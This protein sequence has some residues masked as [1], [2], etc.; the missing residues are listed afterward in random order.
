[1]ELQAQEDRRIKK[2]AAEAKEA[3][4]RHKRNIA[5][6]HKT[7]DSAALKV[8]RLE[9]TLSSASRSSDRVGYTL[10]NFDKQKYLCIEGKE[11]IRVI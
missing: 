4:E 9:N 11:I 10:S 8:R 1:M 5:N 7:L 3:T 6:Y 2:L